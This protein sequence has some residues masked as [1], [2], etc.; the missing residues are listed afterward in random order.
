MPP[1]SKKPAARPRGGS[2]RTTGRARPAP[3]RTLADLVAR[4]GGEVAGDASV[5]VTRIA[6]LDSAGPGDLVFIT[7][8]R[9]LERL[10]DTRA[11]AVILAPA[12]RGATA[13]PRI[14]T[15]NPYAYFARV[16]ALFNPPPAVKAGVHRS[17]VVERTA[18][19][20]KGASVGANAVIAAGAVIGA[21][22]VVGAGC[23]VGEG[24]AVGADSRLHANVTLHHGCT[25]GERCIV[26]SGVV[27]GADGFGIAKDGD[28][29]VKIP[30]VGR[31]VIAD[32]VEI[33]ANTTIDRGAL[34]DTVIEEGVK[35]DNQIQIGHNVRIGAHT[36]IAACTGIA[37]SA[38]IGRYCALGGAAM[39]YGHITIADRV[40]VSA[41][42]LVMK[43]LD[44]PGTYT[45][46]Y[47]FQSHDK[48]LKNAA[49]LRQLDDIADRLK[50]LERLLAAEEKK[51]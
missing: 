10:G 1:K 49:Q 51:K 38:K 39:I 26:H 41:G 23:Y 37:G 3:G 46:V 36:A 25:L 11:S 29:W 4:F 19:V 12:A 50:A 44:K 32:D 40:N 21:R 2:P 9:Y 14:V 20:A 48:W 6:P 7:Q 17:A 18:K 28:A 16:S 13:L 45:G 33:G 5:R 43:S 27:I 35:L 47:P 31:V 34:D 15:D 8:S 22:A 24:A 30:Q 42:T